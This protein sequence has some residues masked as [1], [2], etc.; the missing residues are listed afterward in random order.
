MR[1]GSFEGGKERGDGGVATD[2]R[3][4]KEG[5]SEVCEGRLQGLV[6]EREGRRRELRR[7]GKTRKRKRKVGW[8]GW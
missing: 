4:D 5:G 3:K 2:G 7:E 8:C 6:Y 1:E